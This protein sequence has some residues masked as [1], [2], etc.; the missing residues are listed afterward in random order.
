MTHEVN[1]DMQGVIAPTADDEHK[2]IVNVV[3]GNEQEKI[4]MVEDVGIIQE[5]IINTSGDDQGQIFIITDVEGQQQVADVPDCD[6]EEEI[7]TGAGYDEQL[8]M[9]YAEENAT[10]AAMEKSEQQYDKEVADDE[11]IILYFFVFY[12]ILL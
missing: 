10:I 8:G 6:V 9:K 1:D 3:E 5:E 12:T 2:E 4:T 11:V 7:V